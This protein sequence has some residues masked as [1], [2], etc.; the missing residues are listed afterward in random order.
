MIAVTDGKVTKG[1]K[2]RLAQ[3]G[4]DYEVLELGLMYPDETPMHTLYAGQVGYIITGMKVVREARVG[5]TLYHAQKPVTPFPGF[6]P[7]KP[8]V[9]AGTYP[10]ESTD[11]ELL[12]DAIEKL[13]LNDASVTVT[14]TTSVALGL[15]FRCG[16]LGLLH[17]DVFTQ[18]LDQEYNL[19][20]I[21]T[22]PSVLYKVQLKYNGTTI[23]VEN[24]ADLPDPQQIEHILEPM[25]KATIIVPTIY[26]GNM[27]TP[28]ASQDEASKRI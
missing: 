20:V 4:N 14:K 16:F 22:S 9:F 17:M 2:I 19:A 3:S 26:L 21:A 13:T 5:D 27:L 7:A 24:P 6:K 11:F 18:R 12:R 23:D 25:I 10:V 15:G 28:S 1:D 8:M